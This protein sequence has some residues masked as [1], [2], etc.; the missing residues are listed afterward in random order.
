MPD[1]PQGGRFGLKPD[2]RNGRCWSAPPLFL[3]YRAIL[4]NI[5]MEHML[6]VP[7][8]GLEPPLPREKQIL[9]L[10]RLPIPPRGHLKLSASKLWVIFTIGGSIVLVARCR[11]TALRAQPV[12]DGAP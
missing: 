6:M 9:S 8:E 7:S 4:Q 5:Y 12:A 3:A 10:P 11:A 2:A 1:G